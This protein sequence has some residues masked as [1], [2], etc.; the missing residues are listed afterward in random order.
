MYFLED[1]S[2]T[3]HLI[4]VYFLR[5]KTK[6]APNAALSKCYDFFGSVR[7]LYGISFQTPISEP[8]KGMLKVLLAYFSVTTVLSQANFKPHSLVEKRVKKSLLR[9][10]RER[11]KRFSHRADK[12]GEF[13]VEH[14]SFVD[15]QIMILQQHSN[16]N[17]GPA[18]PPLLLLALIPQ[19]SSGL[20]GFSF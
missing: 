16:Y 5:S 4:C 3:F 9:E 1:L 13:P 14:R 10:M 18:P 19:K 8:Q 6:Q 15:V 11:R 7:W 17:S 20:Y 12:V 2:Y